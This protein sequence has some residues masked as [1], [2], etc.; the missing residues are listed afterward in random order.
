VLE[1]AHQYTGLAGVATKHA[2]A[3]FVRLC[4]ASWPGKVGGQT[5]RAMDYPW[6]GLALADIRAR[7][8]DW[9]REH[10]FIGTTAIELAFI[11]LAALAAWS[12]APRLRRAADAL[13]VRYAGL[14]AVERLWRILG[15]VM[16]PLLWLG[17]QWVAIGI[18]ELAGW[19]SGLLNV[20][21]SLLSAWVVIR[22]ASSFVS[23]AFVSSSIAAVA[24][25]IAALNILG[26]LDQTV[27]LLDR[28][29]MQFGDTR[30][31]A[32]AVIKGLLA[33]AVLLW[34]SLL[35]GNLLESR[36]RAARGLTP[37]LQVLFV[38]V[39]KVILVVI[40]FVAAISSVGINLTAFA[41]F[42]GAIGVGL[43]FGL[44]KIV[45]NLISGVILLLDKSIKPG[46]VIAVG[47][48][49]GRVDTLGARYVSVTTRDGIEHL[50][51]NEELIVN[52]VENWSHSQELYR[53]KLPVGVHY[54]ADVPLAME[55]C[56]EGTR[57]V[58]RV[59]A[60]PAP[61]CL[62]RGF[63]DSS[64]DLEVRFWI[65]DP[66]NG[67][68]NVKSDIYLRIWQLFHE[69]GIEIPYP[70]RDIHLRTPE[71]G[72]SAVRQGLRD[73]GLHQPPER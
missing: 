16:T 35:I 64:V 63:G 51:P 17:L 53:I 61:V 56:L 1:S 6:E 42:G 54:K 44:Q 58:S 10:V 71:L 50:I 2:M 48:Y 9:S 4:T 68:A 47:A 60:Q 73:G 36:I 69:R 13:E 5:E 25:L 30:I 46:D 28:L 33:L 15:L 3:R 67:R 12:L 24:W 19:R 31:S 43:G 40:A 52:R 8:F 11:A 14:W 57:G 66:M 21:A 62:L 34:L 20:T 65:N 59:L 23:D 72:D 26:V 18:S 55:L 45:S 27:V 70:Q 32:Y 29:A 49:Y 22:V 39:L 37:S 7:V 38:K 41:V